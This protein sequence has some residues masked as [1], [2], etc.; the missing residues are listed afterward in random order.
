MRRYIVGKIAVILHENHDFSSIVYID[1]A[2]S[3]VKC[4]SASELRGAI[5][6][7]MLL[8]NA[9]LKPVLS[10]TICLGLRL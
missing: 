4:F 10:F 5:R 1:D 3:M 2:P 8:G 6:T 7:Y 9:V